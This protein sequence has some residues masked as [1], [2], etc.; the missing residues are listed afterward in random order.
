VA[1][2]GSGHPVPKPESNGDDSTAWYESWWFWTAVGVVVAGS[3]TALTLWLVQPE[4][5][6]TLVV[7]PRR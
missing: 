1:V 3:A 6:W 5:S 4:E 7:Q 2:P